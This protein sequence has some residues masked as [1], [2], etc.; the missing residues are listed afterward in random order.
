MFTRM[1]LTELKVELANPEITIPCDNTQTIRLINGE[2]SQL[3]TKLRHVDIH[4][5]WLRQEAKNRTINVVY[6]PSGEMLADGLT[7]I[8]PANNWPQFLEQLGLVDVKE[9]MCIEEAD[10]EQIMDMMESLGI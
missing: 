4:N 9:H 7:K 2:I 1:L 6:V 3:T 10:P 5:H 8:L